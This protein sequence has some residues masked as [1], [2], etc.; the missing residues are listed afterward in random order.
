MKHFK[1]P[2]SSGLV[3][4]FW[5]FSAFL[6]ASFSSCSPT[7]KQ[8]DE[9]RQGLADEA[10]TL[11]EYISQTGAF[12]FSDSTSIAINPLEINKLAD[13]NILVLDIRNSELFA[14]GHIA[15]AV[16]LGADELVSFFESSIQPSAFEK[17]IIVDARGQNA[18]YA[19]ALMRLIGYNN[20]YFLK[21][22]M[23]AWNKKLA[24]TGWDAAISDTLS[25]K[26]E[27]DARSK[28]RFNHPRPQLTTGGSNAF[29][30]ARLRA[31][32][33]LSKD[34]PAF[35]LDFKEILKKPDQYYLLSLVPADIYLKAGHLPGAMPCEPNSLWLSEDALSALPNDK[36]IAFYSLTGHSA[37][38]LVALLRMLGYNAHSVYYGASSFMYKTLFN[39]PITA[40][41]VWDAK[42][43]GDFPLEAG[44]GAKPA[45]GIVITKA[46]KGGC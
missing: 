19:A 35:L 11:A 41:R 45:G 33:L 30:V 32:Q 8:N 18:A 40:S 6:L 9:Q 38:E 21:Y 43:A 25:G 17:I 34:S 29:D 39:T 36:A 37:A 16:N 31:S 24:L 7:A 4:G 44:Q 13:K 23:S 27:L 26:L 46:A 12:L 15:A 1:N 22:G 28:D 5:L 2:F 20:V 10:E 3:F 42:Q 14:A